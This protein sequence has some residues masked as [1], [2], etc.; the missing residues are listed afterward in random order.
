MHLGVSS[1]LP[2][3]SVLPCMSRTNLGA[4]SLM[5]KANHPLLW[6]HCV[7]RSRLGAGLQHVTQPCSLSLLWCDGVNITPSH[8]AGFVPLLSARPSFACS[9]GLNDCISCTFSFCSQFVLCSIGQRSYIT[10]K[11]VYGLFPAWT[12][13]LLVVQGLSSLVRL[14][15]C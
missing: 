4:I 12:I 9:C 13:V 2:G 5:R 8:A 14:H 1:C 6:Q 15:N 11:L 3:V 10:N 7:A